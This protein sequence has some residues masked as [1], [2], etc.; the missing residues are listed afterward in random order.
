MN[1]QYFEN[2]QNAINAA[3][4]RVAGKLGDF[5]NGLIPPDNWNN[6]HD[7]HDRLQNR[8]LDNWKEYKSWHWDKYGFNAY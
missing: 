4:E 3:I 1:L 2:K 8:L 5:A 7:L 6:W